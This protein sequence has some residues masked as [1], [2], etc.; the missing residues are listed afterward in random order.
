MTRSGLRWWLCAGLAAWGAVA[1]GCPKA[2]T[3]PFAGPS[4]FELGPEKMVTADLSMPADSPAVA[5]DGEDFL[6]V[7]SARRGP[8]TDLFGV[9]VAPDGNPVDRSPKI[10][11]SSPGNQK[12]PSV[13]W[14]GDLFLVVWEDDR[15][16]VTRIFGAHVTP[17]GEV[18]ESNGFPVARGRYE[19]TSPVAGWTGSR[20][21]VVWTESVGGGSGLD[22]YGVVLDP[23]IS[24]AAAE[25]MP[26]VNAPGN[27]LEPAMA[28]GP[29][30]GLLVWSDDRSGGTDASLI[31]LY[32]IRLGVDGHRLGPDTL[33]VTGAA[34]A[35]HSPAVAWDGMQ[36]D[37]AWIDRREGSDL[38]YGTAISAKGV[39]HDPGGVQITTGP[40]ENGPPALA[41]VENYLTGDT[42]RRVVGVWTDNGQGQQLVLG[43]LWPGGFEPLPSV[44]GAM[45]YTLGDTAR[46]VR[47]AATDRG[48]LLVVWAGL[49]SGSGAAEQVFYKQIVVKQ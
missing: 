32:A 30:S 4:P 41:A 15:S 38:I 8:G 47:T 40:N 25:A 27:Q 28:W 49:P 7:W 14:G 43:R 48:E 24:G 35:Q 17:R 33:L 11:S 46:L 26:L 20:Y 12:H 29:D 39:I 37:L 13:A 34:G 16:G 31:D 9:R 19:Q 6:V 42:R 45:T 18:L 5:W 21:V 44:S 2:G 1:A 36:F 3:D 23:S 22:L 10:I